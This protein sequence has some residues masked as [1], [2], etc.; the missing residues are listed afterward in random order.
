MCYALGMEVKV[1]PPHLGG[2]GWKLWAQ[3]W[4]SL[5]SAHGC[6]GSLIGLLILRAEHL[7]VEVTSSEDSPSFLH[8]HPVPGIR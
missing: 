8:S 7:L 2:L 3:G 4:H 5:C 1:V 6:Q